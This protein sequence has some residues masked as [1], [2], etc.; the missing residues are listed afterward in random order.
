MRVQCKVTAETLS[1]KTSLIEFLTANISGGGAFIATDT[2]LRG[3]S[4]NL[5]RRAAMDPRHRDSHQT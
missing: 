2:P 5:A 1:G 4:V 3:M